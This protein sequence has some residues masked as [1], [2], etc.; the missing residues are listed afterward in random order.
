MKSLAESLC[1]FI[2]WLDNW[3]ESQE[4]KRRPSSGIPSGPSNKGVEVV[5]FYAGPRDG[6]QILYCGLVIRFCGHPEGAY[7]FDGQCYKWIH[8]GNAV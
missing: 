8:H 6:D 2:E 1:R 5:R 7:C 3:L 4:S